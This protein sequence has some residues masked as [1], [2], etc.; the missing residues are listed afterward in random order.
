MRD[1]KGKHENNSGF[2]YTGEWLAD[3]RHGFGKQD[4]DNGDMYF[5][6][7]FEDLQEGNGTFQREGYKFTG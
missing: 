5:G 6:Q 2:H 4:F 7:W 3:M 1:G